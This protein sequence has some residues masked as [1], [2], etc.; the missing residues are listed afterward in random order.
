MLDECTISNVLRDFNFTGSPHGSL[1]IIKLF[2]SMEAGL[3]IICSNVEVYREM[4][5]EYRCGILVDPNDSEQ[6]MNA[7]MYLVNNKEDAYQM[8]QEGRR[9]VREKFNWEAESKKYIEKINNINL[10]YN[11]SI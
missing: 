7:I 8:G 11:V 2:E 1:G 3:P 9:A 6:I 4:M 5:N 10:K